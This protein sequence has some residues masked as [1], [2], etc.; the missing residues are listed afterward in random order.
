MLSNA[1]MQESAVYPISLDPL[2]LDIERFIETFYDSV[3]FTPNPSSMHTKFKQF[4]I[5]G[6]RLSLIQQFVDAYTNK[7]DE[8]VSPLKLIK[9][10]KECSNFNELG[11]LQHM[12]CLTRNDIVRYF[13]SQIVITATFNISIILYSKSLDTRIAFQL[14]CIVE[15]SLRGKIDFLRSNLNVAFQPIYDSYSP[16]DKLKKN[17]ILVLVGNEESFG[18]DI[19]ASA[20]SAEQKTEL[21]G[22]RDRIIRLSNGLLPGTRFAPETNMVLKS[23]NEQVALEVKLK[24]IGG[25]ILGTHEVA[26]ITIEDYIALKRAKYGMIWRKLLV[27]FGA[28]SEATTAVVGAAEG[29]AGGASAVAPTDAIDPETAELNEAAGC[30]LGASIGAANVS[31]ITTQTDNDIS[32][33][34]SSLFG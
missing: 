2:H 5:N 31:Q 15:L 33:G 17:L 10:I 1:E 8:V 29:C 22:R 24:G 7:H 18:R 25:M 12:V 34:F 27:A 13:S 6:K 26:A 19:E 28:E 21:L 30:T 11:N 9:V 20:L 4:T 23:L 16:M 3:S 14:P 32:S